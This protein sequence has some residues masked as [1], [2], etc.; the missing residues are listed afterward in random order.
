[1]ENFT[2]IVIILAVFA[3]GY[4][5]NRLSNWREFSALWNLLCGLIEEM[6]DVFKMIENEIP[7][8]TSNENLK[9]IDQFCKRAVN[10]ISF[11]EIFMGGKKNVQQNNQKSGIKGNKK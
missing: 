8:N 1:M 3:T 9:R 5:V 6:K 7:D 11:V 2:V 10:S 4:L